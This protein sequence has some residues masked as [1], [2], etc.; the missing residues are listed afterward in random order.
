MDLS[1]EENVKVKAVLPF[2][3]SLGFQ[4][5]ELHFEKSFTF[6]SGSSTYRT[7]TKKQCRTFSPRLDILV[8]RNGINLFIVEVKNDD[9]AISEKDVAQATSYALAVFPPAPFAIVTNGE[10]FHLYDSIKREEI[11]EGAFKIKDRYEVTISEEARYEALKHFIGYSKAN[12]TTFCE[13]QV[14]E[15]MQPLLGSKTDLSK[16]YIP[17]LHIPCQEFLVTCR[18][19][20]CFVGEVLLISA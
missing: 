3:C 12:V 9:V 7:D 15:H 19:F 11:K 8:T 2:L 10:E 17:E 20:R 6:R 5:D 18:N 14:L 1:V 16:K 4:A 13:Q